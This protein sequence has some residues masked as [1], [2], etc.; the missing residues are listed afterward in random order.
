MNIEEQL[1]Q[2][3]AQPRSGFGNLPRITCND[4]FNLSVQASRN[5]YCR[6]RSDKGPWTEVEVGYPSVVEPLLFDHAEVSTYPDYTQ[7]VYPYTP[8][9]VVAAV[10]EVHGGFSSCNPSPGE[11]Y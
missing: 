8:V 5:H 6:P 7:Q 2:Y 4:G 9:S 3:L 11:I 1:Q 10:I